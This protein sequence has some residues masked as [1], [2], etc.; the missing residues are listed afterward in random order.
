MTAE[1]S[2]MSG[3]ARSWQL[4]VAFWI[5]TYALL[6]LRGALLDEPVAIL[7]FRRLIATAAGAL[8]FVLVLQSMRRA[9]GRPTAAKVRIALAVTVPTVLSM[10]ALRW[11]LESWVGGRAAAPAQS[12]V[13]TIVW[14]GYFAAWVGICIAFDLSGR[15]GAPHPPA[16]AEPAAAEPAADGG[17]WLEGQGRAERVRIDAIEWV[18][19]EGNYVRIHS[20]G[21]SALIRLPLARIEERLRRHGFVRVHRSA[22]CRAAAVTAVRRKQTGAFVAMLRSGAEIPVSRAAVPALREQKERALA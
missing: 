11:G 7:H 22:L 12:L 6:S 8:L 15:I 5:F 9:A 21:G 13:W 4:A 2:Q 20:D 1:D 16:A 3:P 14:T 18:Q 10:L 17:A 19:A